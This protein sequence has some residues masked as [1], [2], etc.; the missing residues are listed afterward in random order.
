MD[1]V[2]EYE[3][4]L[5]KTLR[6]IRIR[7]FFCGYGSKTTHEYIERMKQEKWGFLEISGRDVNTGKNMDLEQK[8]FHLEVKSEKAWY[9][10]YF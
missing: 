2:Q 5:K 6:G 10:L 3:K 7:I 4:L 9:R 8:I 1:C